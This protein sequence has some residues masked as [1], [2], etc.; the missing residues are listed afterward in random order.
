MSPYV[1]DIPLS[2]VDGVVRTCNPVTT[3]STSN[4]TESSCMDSE[5]KFELQQVQT[6]DTK[7]LIIF[8]MRDG[9]KNQDTI[10]FELL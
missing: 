1:V 10:S 9:L 2:D 6:E 4:G 5:K 8:S 7:G 3:V